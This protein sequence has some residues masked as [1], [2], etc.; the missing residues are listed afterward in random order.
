MLVSKAIVVIEGAMS[1]RVLS[2]EKY[3]GFSCNAWLDRVEWFAP[4]AT[5][6]G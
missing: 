5:E 2:S 4:L 3:H 1:K 6:I